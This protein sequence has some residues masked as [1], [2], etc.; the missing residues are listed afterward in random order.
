MRWMSGS[1]FALAVAAALMSFVGTA[2]ARNT[3]VGANL[4]VAITAPV[5]LTRY[6]DATLQVIT[7]NAG[8]SVSASDTTVAITLPAGI[9]MTFSNNAGG[10]GPC[11]SGTPMTCVL[12]SIAAGGTR[13]TTIGITAA[14]VG[15]P[16]VSA[17]VTSS[18]IDP[19]PAD[20]TATA[21]IHV[22]DA[23]GDAGVYLLG[24]T[25]ASVGQSLT[26]QLNLSNAG[27]DR[28]GSVQVS[29][30]IPPGL[31]FGAVSFAGS[32]FCSFSGGATTCF[33]G[34]PSVACKYPAT[35]GS[36]TLT[37][38]TGALSSGSF[39]SAY[40]TVTPN[41]AGTIT[42]TAT[43]TPIA[44]IDPNPANNTAT[45]VTRAFIGTPPPESD[46]EITSSATASAQPGWPLDYYLTVSNHGPDAATAVTVTDTLSP[47]VE[48]YGSL[49]AGCSGTT[50]ITCSLGAIA[51]GNQVTVHLQVRGK[52]VGT[53]TNSAAVSSAVTDLVPVNNSTTAATTLYIPSADLSVTATAP[54]SSVL[55]RPLRATFVV[56]NNGPDTATGV[57]LDLTLP[58]DATPGG[59][60]ASNFA[61][62]PGS[63]SSTSP[64]CA[65][66][67]VGSSSI[68][69]VTVDFY[70]RSL[71]SASVTGHATGLESDPT[72]LTNWATATTTVT[73]PPTA[74]LQLTVGAPAV[75]GL[76]DVFTYVLTA[77]NN[78][79]DD[80]TGVQIH[81]TLP[82]GVLYLGMT[83]AQGF[84]APQGSAGTLPGG[85]FICDVG[86]LAHGASTVVTVQVQTVALGA[87][88]NS[89]ALNGS[90]T[91]PD[92]TNDYRET[93]TSV[94]AGPN[95]TLD[96]APL[97]A[98]TEQTATFTF[99]STPAPLRF[100]C[101]LDALAFRLCAS[102]LTY[103]G[104]AAGP[105][106]FRVRAIDAL[107]NPDPTPASKFW[108]IVGQGAP[109][110]VIYSGPPLTTSSRVAEFAFAATLS[111]SRFQCALD[112]G[113]W[114]PCSSILTFHGLP[115]GLHWLSVRAVGFD[116]QVDQT[117][118]VYVWQITVPLK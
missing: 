59:I 4:S 102:G 40:L 19:I 3:A 75:Q 1:A 82:A 22:P 32:T 61:S 26:Y 34:N 97:A 8:P 58:P 117:P 30:P 12:G 43:M 10:V 65:L 38:S 73:P 90:Q 52:S 63:F 103:H 18:G 83:F 92:R 84:C 77:V 54:S 85:Q 44:G 99:S 66:G 28:V 100:Q 118:S 39:G 101:S 55:N 56:R 23:T 11:S 116:G 93:T 104:L 78:G 94:L 64:Y 16:V 36:R 109:D 17:T 6:A 5:T 7:T 67:S 113:A 72:P 76:G 111:G 106:T 62:C 108:V 14:S 71:G 21:T 45:L 86:A 57:L 51:F 33:G 79:P 112:T 49:P 15:D 107:D 2:G 53:A 9:G 48:L 25:R 69:T 98:S 105:H 88:L 114:R 50:T 24:P 60:F 81:D 115:A 46:L 27:P 31:D 74:D 80:A 91:D 35:A 95:T 20:N 89:A 13:T 96:S 68:V 29:L 42:S 110:T 37:C 47:L 41:A 87:A 70:P